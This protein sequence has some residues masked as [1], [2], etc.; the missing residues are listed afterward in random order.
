MLPDVE[1]LG[2]IDRFD[3]VPESE[4]GASKGGQLA[5]G[6]ARTTRAMAEGRSPG[7]RA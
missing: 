7:R 1:P 4:Q 5:M 6:N 2:D 3:A